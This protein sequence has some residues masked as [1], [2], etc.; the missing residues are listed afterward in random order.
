MTWSAQLPTLAERE[1]FWRGLRSRGSLCTP[2]ASWFA[3]S[4]N[5]RISACADHT[6]R[7]EGIWRNCRQSLKER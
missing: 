2:S 3:V 5:A 4:L 7:A 1:Q 6:I